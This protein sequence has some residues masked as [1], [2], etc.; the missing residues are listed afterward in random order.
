MDW[1]V[2]PPRSGSSGSRGGT[3]RGRPDGSMP[4]IPCAC[5]APHIR[6]ATTRPT[7]TLLP[8]LLEVLFA[9]AQQLGAPRVGCRLVQVIRMPSPH[10][11]KNLVVEDHERKSIRGLLPMRLPPTAS[12]SSRVTGWAPPHQGRAGSRNINASVSPF[13]RRLHGIVHTQEPVRVHDA[14]PPGVALPGAFHQDGRPIAEPHLARRDGDIAAR[15]MS[16]SGRRDRAIVTLERVL[17]QNRNV[18]GC[19]SAGVFR[20]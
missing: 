17:C 13:S 10:S 11:W 18:P 16:E 8:G 15:S 5:A 3:R 12:R 9:F 20:R 14:N 19:P 2:V 7:Q 1:A 6:Q 4:K